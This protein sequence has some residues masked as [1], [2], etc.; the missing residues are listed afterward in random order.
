[1]QVPR[2]DDRSQRSDVRRQKSDDRGRKDTDGEAQKLLNVV[3]PL[4]LQKDS[5]KG[6]NREEIKIDMAVSTNHK[7]NQTLCQKQMNRQLL[8]RGLKSRNS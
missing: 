2:S 6:Y 3:C 7:R 1:M 4:F 8:C 5:I